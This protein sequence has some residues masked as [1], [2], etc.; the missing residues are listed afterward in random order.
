VLLFDTPSIRPPSATAVSQA[1]FHYELKP[2]PPNYEQLKRLLSQY[3]V[4][5]NTSEEDENTIQHLLCTTEQLESRV[6]ASSAEILAGL[7]KF[8]AF[9]Y[10]GP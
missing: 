1:T 9:I 6:Q 4:D 2:I 3:P 8:E 10:K 5:V 7:N